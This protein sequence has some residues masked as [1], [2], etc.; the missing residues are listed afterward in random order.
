MKRN[1]TIPP[2]DLLKLIQGISDVGPL[3]NSG[4]IRAQDKDENTILHL[5]VERGLENL[6][7]PLARWIPPSSIP[8]HDGW[9]PLHLTVRNNDERMTK[10]LV[11]AGPDIS[12]QDQSGKTALHC[13][14]YNDAVKIVRF[15]LDQG[16]NPS[17][18]DY[19]GSTPLHEGLA[20][21][22]TPN[23]AHERQVPFFI[24]LV[25]VEKVLPGSF[26]RLEQILSFKQ[27]KGETLLQRATSGNHS[28][29]MRVLLDAG[30]D[31]NTRDS[32]NGYTA[33]LRAASRGADDALRLLQK[34]GADI[35]AGDYH[36]RNA[37]HLAARTEQKPSTA[38]LLLKAGVNPSAQDWQGYTPLRYAVEAGIPE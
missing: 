35:L 38:K 24:W 6:I 3:L 36:R 19:E 20:P 7:K 27:R 22:L 32:Y 2:S 17:A 25:W 28:N 1:A 10:A 30:V 31:V 16:A 4:H 12:A 23:A 11:H 26:L 15:L 37:L 5:I 34:N 29:F 21:S 14:C 8:N 18:A 13:A 9:T 33:V